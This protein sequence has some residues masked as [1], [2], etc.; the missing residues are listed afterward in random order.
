LRRTRVVGEQAGGLSRWIEKK[1]KPS[2]GR[3]RGRG[4][5]RRGESGGGRAQQEQ[6]QRWKL[7]GRRLARAAGGEGAEGR[8][9]ATDGC[10][11]DRSS[12]ADVGSWRGGGSSEVRWER[13]GRGEA[14]SGNK[15]RRGS[16]RLSVGPCRGTNVEGAEVGNGCEW[17]G[18][19]RGR[20]SAA[21]SK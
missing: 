2:R 9:T 12:T 19:G 4:S 20:G 7:T 13:V 18:G 15:P 3:G 6:R 1:K 5:G 14:R 16:G 17:R 8:A 11:Q 10:R 21:H